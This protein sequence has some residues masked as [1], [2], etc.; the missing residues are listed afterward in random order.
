M[1]VRPTSTVISQMEWLPASCSIQ[2]G[3]GKLRSLLNAVALHRGSSLLYQW[4][5]L[6][7]VWR[8]IRPV[9][10]RSRHGP[11]EPSSVVELAN[12]GKQ[13]KTKQ[14]AAWCISPFQKFVFAAAVV[15]VYKKVGNIDTSSPGSFP[16]QGG[17]KHK[18]LNRHLG[19]QRV[20]LGERRGRE[21]LGMVFSKD[22]AT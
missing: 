6:P 2:K 4:R 14:N 10:Q 12:K 1:T 11:R 21:W 9:H 16:L 8:R 19:C 22:Y 3:W 17:S 13:N 20:S 18:P 5:G 7:Y 15:V